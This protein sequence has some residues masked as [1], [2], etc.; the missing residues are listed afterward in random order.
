MHRGLPC[1]STGLSSSQLGACGPPGTS[2]STFS[3]SGKT[4][5]TT[6]PTCDV[7]YTLLIQLSIIQ[8]PKEIKPRQMLLFCTIFF[9]DIS[10]NY[11][12]NTTS[13]IILEPWT[14]IYEFSKF[15]TIQT[16]QKKEKELI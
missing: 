13:F 5:M 3:S 6:G 11:E 8:E 10:Q 2:C 14:E 7:M 4:P 16:I 12:S 9:M 1:S 15:E